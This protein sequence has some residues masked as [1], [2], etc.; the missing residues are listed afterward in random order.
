MKDRYKGCLILILILAAWVIAALVPPEWT[1]RMITCR[2]V[3]AETG[4]PIGG[5]AVYIYW[6]KLE[7]SIGLSHE[8]TIERFEDV[9]GEQ[10]YTEIPKYSFG[11]YYMVVYKRDYV[12]WSSDKIFPSWTRRDSFNLKNGVTISMERFRPE[13]SRKDHVR[14]IRFMTVGRDVSIFNDI[15]DQEEVLE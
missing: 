11:R 1:R 3:D 2:V 9:S 10:G 7:G 8:A 6:S 15:I 12:C 4:E 5:A 14:F 13:Y